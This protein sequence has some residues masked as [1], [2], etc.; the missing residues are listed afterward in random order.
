M[1]RRII[2]FIGKIAKKEIEIIS[3]EER[4]HFIVGRGTKY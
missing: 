4:D 3:T 1:Y 2:V